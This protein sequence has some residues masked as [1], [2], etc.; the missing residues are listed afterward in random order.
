MLLLRQSQ[1]HSR[2]QS[3]HSLQHPVHAQCK[4]LSEDGR[5]LKTSGSLQ[6]KKRA[7]P[8]MLLVKDTQKWGTYSHSPS[9]RTLNDIEHNRIYHGLYCKTNSLPFLCIC[10]HSVVSLS[11]LEENGFT[12][13]N[14]SQEKQDCANQVLVQ[15]VKWNELVRKVYKNKQNRMPK[16]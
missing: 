6:M 7:R 10:P 9:R 4:R 11:Y 1:V 8:I 3:H 5:S 15:T 16:D 12:I 13:G 14:L 2:A